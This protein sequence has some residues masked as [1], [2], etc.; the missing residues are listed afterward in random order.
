[1]NTFS[2]AVR[3]CLNV[4]SSMSVARPR[5]SQNPVGGRAPVSRSLLTILRD[6][7]EEATREAGA[8]AEAATSDE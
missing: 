8:K 4:S 3:R 6:H 1:M 2:S 7:D 5:G